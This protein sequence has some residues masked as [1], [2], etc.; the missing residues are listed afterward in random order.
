MNQEV[1][2]VINLLRDVKTV[3]GLI[4]DEVKHNDDSCQLVGMATCVRK[5]AMFLN[6][7]NN[8][9]TEQ[10]KVQSVFFFC[11]LNC[12]KFNGTL[13]GPVIVTGT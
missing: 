8:T 13:R 6:Q 1:I 10:R 3:M 4:C 2:A 5:I 11:V 9:K 12:E 7:I